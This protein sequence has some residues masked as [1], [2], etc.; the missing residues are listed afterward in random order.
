MYTPYCN[1]EAMIAT[2]VHKAEPKWQ[3][4]PMFALTSAKRITA[5]KMD[6]RRQA[7]GVIANVA[8]LTLNEGPPGPGPDDAVGFDRRCDRKYT[9]E[10]MMV[11]MVQRIIPYVLV[12]PQVIPNVWCE[13]VGSE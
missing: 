3:T 9:R 5:V 8:K 12:V 2:E 13:D 7:I 6:A 10:E 11:R 1:K 4:V